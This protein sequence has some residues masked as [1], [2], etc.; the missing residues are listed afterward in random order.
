MKRKDAT[1]LIIG[2][3]FVSY[4]WRKWGHFVLDYLGCWLSSVFNKRIVLN[5]GK[6]R[7][8][9]ISAYKQAD[10]FLFGSEVECAPLVMYESFAS[11]T[12]FISTPVGNVP[13]YKNI[14]KIVKN[15]NE[16]AGVSNYLLDNDEARKNVSKKAFSEW[17]EKYTWDKIA[18]EY[19]KLFK[20][21]IYE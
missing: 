10:I 21:L 7:E 12:P 8:F 2:N 16:M 6:N 19:E 9:V 1:L 3:K 14:V 5:N 17:K 15:E 18:E 4:G 13:D 11:K 20:S